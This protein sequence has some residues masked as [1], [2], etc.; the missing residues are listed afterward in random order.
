MTSWWDSPFDFWKLDEILLKNGVS[1]IKIMLKGQPARSCVG[2]M[3]KVGYEP[4]IVERRPGV[5]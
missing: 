2:W 3:L 5:F 4:E 1:D